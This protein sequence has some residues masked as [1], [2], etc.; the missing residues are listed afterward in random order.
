[1]KSTGIVS[2]TITVQSVDAVKSL[3]NVSMEL[4]R[5]RAMIHG[6]TTESSTALATSR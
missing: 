2:I 1:M 5:F 6:T 4:H 3:E